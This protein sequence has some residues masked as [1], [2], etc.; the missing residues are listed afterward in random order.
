MGASIGLGESMFHGHHESPPRRFDRILFVNGLRTRGGEERVVTDLARGLVR[1]GYEVAAAC[2]AQG[3]AVDDMRSAG[4]SIFDVKL[5]DKN[6]V[7]SLIGIQRA[8]RRWEPALVHAHGSYAGLYGRVA[9]FLLRVPVAWTVH[10]HPLWRDGAQLTEGRRYRVVYRTVLRA[11]DHMAAETVFVSSG[12]QEAFTEFLGRTPARST[13]VQNGIDVEKYRPSASRRAALRDRL[14]LRDSDVV[15]GAAGRLIPRKGFDTLLRSIALVRNRRVVTL[16]AGDGPERA[17]LEALAV[18]LG[19]ADRVRFL[20]LVGDM[21]RFLPGFD[22]GVLASRGEG[23]PL[24]ALEMLATGV[25]VVL[26]DIPMHE[27]FDALRPSVRYARTDD[28]EAF[29]TAIDSFLDA[30]N[31]ATLREDARRKVERGFSLDTMVDAYV[32]LY[33]RLLDGRVR[34]RTAECGP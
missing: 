21:H 33:D 3:V 6:S 20:G 13:L 31:R 18:G 22:V 23:M 5:R 15:V 12:L 25:P 8:I 32:D 16:I 1:R 11:L 7:G 28:P 4:A 10:L 2:D 9:A 14:G 29:A 30:P 34:A 27:Q 17:E 24:I 19:I 26:S